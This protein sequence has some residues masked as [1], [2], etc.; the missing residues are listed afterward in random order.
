MF[1]CLQEELRVLCLE[2]SRPHSPP[3]A[4]CRAPSSLPSLL[5]SRLLSEPVPGHPLQNESC[6]WLPPLTTY[7]PS[8]TFSFLACYL[9]HHVTY[10]FILLPVLLLTQ[11]SIKKA[12]ALQSRILS[13]LFI[14]F[15]PGP[16]T[17]QAQSVGSMNVVCL[18]MQV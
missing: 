15:S 5:R 6:P 3:P 7:L 18:S 4:V 2:S 12:R 14:A 16:N 13:I 9:T 8:F 17:C 11:P 10:V 1:P